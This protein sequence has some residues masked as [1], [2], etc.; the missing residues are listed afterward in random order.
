MPSDI[1]DKR[2]A[3]VKDWF[4]LIMWYVRL[5]RCARKITPIKLLEIEERI[6]KHKLKDCVKKIKKARLDTYEPN[7]G[8]E[9]EQ[10]SEVEDPMK[11]LY[12]D[13]NA[14][15]QRS[16]QYSDFDSDD[17]LEAHEI[18]HQWK[19]MTSQIKSNKNKRKFLQ[20]VQFHVRIYGLRVN[21]YTQNNSVV[22]NRVVQPNFLFDIDSFNIALNCIN[23]NVQNRLIVN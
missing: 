3:V 22:I 15:V 1:E 21:I 7:L 10:S 2:R 6:Q 4:K 8:S 12:Q 5:R 23:D 16:D 17:I 19:K 11:L 9:G 20:G 18:Q 13:V 14:T